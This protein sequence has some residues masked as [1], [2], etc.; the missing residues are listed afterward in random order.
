MLRPPRSARRAAALHRPHRHLR[1]RSQRAARRLA[2]A[3]GRAVLSGHRR[4]SARSG[5]PP[6]A[7]HDRT[8]GHR[9]AGRG[10]RPRGVRGARASTAA[11]SCSARG[12]CSR[13]LDV[14]RSG[15]MRDIVATI[16]ADQDRAI[17]APLAGVLVVQGGPGTG[18][19]A[20]ALHRTAFLLYA[21][22]ERIARSGVLLVGPNRV[23]LQL[24][25]AGAADPGRDRGGAHGD[26]GRAVPG[27][28][29]RGGRRAAGGRA[30]GRPA[31]GRGDRGGGPRPRSARSI[32]RAASMSTAPS[33]AL[34]PAPVRQARDRARRSGAAAQ[35][36]PG[37]LRRRGPARPGAPARR[38]ARHRA[39]PRDPQ[40]P[41]GAAARIARRAARGQLV[42]G[43]DHARSG[44]CAI[45][46]PTPTT[47]TRP[48]GR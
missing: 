31:H 48:R 30:Q 45:C 8:G 37:R 7:V 29:H 12:R 41:D 11:T 44:C 9:R 28:R 26:A 35:R 17:R 23:F 40:R 46:T 24:H 4:P 13:Q 25:R 47:S 27:R 2:G 20:V 32:G 16:Q 14:A 15:R 3:G 33:I 42:L 1:R 21:N 43:A 22:R 36:G 39:R 5:A 38:G 6:P 18:K 34:E 10:A 19:T